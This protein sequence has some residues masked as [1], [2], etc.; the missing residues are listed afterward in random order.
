M[1]VSLFYPPEDGLPLEGG[2]RS[3]MFVPPLG[4]AYIAGS[5]EQEVDKV[6][7]YDLRDGGTNSVDLKVIVN[8]SDVIGVSIAS[9]SFYNAS[10]LISMI[11]DMDPDIPII[12]GGPHCSLYPTRTLLETRADICIVGEGDFVIKDVI[13]KLDDKDFLKKLQGVIIKDGEKLSDINKPIIIKNLD[14]LPVPAYHLL[15]SRYGKFFDLEFFSSKCTGV[16]TSRGCPFRCRFCSREIAGMNVYRAKSAERVIRELDYVT[17][18]GYRSIVIIDDNF[19]I[20]KT[21]A[22]KI[23][24]SIID[25]KM[26]LEIFLQGVRI[27]S[28]DDSICKLMKKAGVVAIAFG[29]ESGSQKVLD[30]YR[31][32]IDLEQIRRVVKLCAENDIYTI[33][34]F[35]MG[36]P[37][38]TRKDIENTIRF[39]KSLPL[40]FSLFFILE[41]TAGSDLWKAA[42][43]EGKIDEDEYR[44]YADS[45]RGLT[46]FS[47]EELKHYQKKAYISFYADPRYMLREL[48]SAI[49]RNRTHLAK[50]VYVLFKHILR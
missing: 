27:D 23:L 28:V 2:G 31:K 50:Y 20:G 17:D 12:I 40:D 24:R 25:R 35:I 14:K 6:D 1:K 15:R 38:E 5:I 3:F 47:L 22:E 43:S 42:V 33:G 10:L 29:I 26:G 19:L 37:V 39:A 46:K 44:V 34:N 21:R 41:Y 45:S 32:G 11:K 30:F 4:L 49:K 16:E 18:L 9:F 7:I 48:R 36:A 13:K 8:R